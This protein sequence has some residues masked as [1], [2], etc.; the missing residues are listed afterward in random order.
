M[1][2]AAAER[3]ADRV[4]IRDGDTT[5]SFAELRAAA[6]RFG[7]ALVA[8]GVDPGDRVAIWAFNSVEWVIAV[9]GIFAAGGVLV[10]VNTRFKG[11]EAADMLAR[12]GARALVTVTDFLGNDYVAM[13]Q[14]A[15]RG[16]PGAR[17]HRGRS[18]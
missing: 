17:D 9:L 4:A 12:S 16:A 6:D 11:H 10:P 15:E 2:A 1:V 8:S 5:L 14:Q 13:L 7:A 3:F 18:R